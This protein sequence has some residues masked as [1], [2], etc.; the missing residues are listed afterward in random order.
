MAAMVGYS[1]GWTV[2]APRFPPVS[3]I[4]GKL[5]I[6]PKT[7]TCQ[8]RELGPRIRRYQGSLARYSSSKR[9]VTCP[10]RSPGLRVG[11]YAMTGESNRCTARSVQEDQRLDLIHCGISPG[12]CDQAGECH[13]N[14]T[15]HEQDQQI[16]GHV[17][18]NV[19]RGST[20]SNR[21]DGETHRKVGLYPLQKIRESG[22]RIRPLISSY[23][24]H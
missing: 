8:E 24:Q 4:C 22:N 23:L 2:R 17:G 3:T 1:P 10:P 21:I 18:L 16:L 20:S 15:E 14:Q 9:S 13:R 12:A 11:E 19:R 7:T 6:P 5:T